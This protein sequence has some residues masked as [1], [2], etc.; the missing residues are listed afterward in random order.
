MNLHK[1]KFQTPDLAYFCMEFG[2]E[3]E[4]PNYAGGLG[5][6]AADILQAL[7]DK[8]INACG[9][10]LMYK[11]GFYA[12]D[13]YYDGDVNFFPRTW[14]RDK[15]LIKQ[16]V[17]T[18]VKIEGREVKI[19]VW[20]Y[21]LETQGK[22]V[23]I[24]LLDTDLS[25][26]DSRDRNITNKLYSGGDYLRLAQEVVLG[27]GGVKVLREMGYEDIDIYHMNEGHAAFLTLQLLKERGFK[28]ERVQENCIFT[29]HTPI[30]AGHDK[31]DYDLAHQVVGD[32]LPWHIQELAGE[33]QLSM[34]ELAFS[35]SRDANAVSRRHK[36]VTQ[37]MFPNK[38]I[39]Y[40]TNG[41][42][43]LRWTSEN[44][45]EVYDEYMPGWRDNP[46]ICEKQAESI[47]DEEFY[48]AHQEDKKE[49]LELVNRKMVNH[50]VGHLD[51]QKVESFY[52]DTETLTISF[53][54]RTVPYKR[55]ELLFRN[56]DRL[57][58]LGEGKLQII[59]AGKAHPGDEFGKQVIK[60]ITKL[61]HELAG[62]INIFYLE[63]YDIETAKLLV[64]GSDVWLN[65]PERPREA[66]GTSGMK[67]A[68]NGMLN[69]SIYDGWWIEG[70]EKCPDSGW[71]I[72]DK[73]LS[74]NPTNDD[75]ADVQSLYNILEKEIIPLY[76]HDRE[77]WLQCSKKAISLMS[78][79]AAKRCIEEYNRKL[80]HL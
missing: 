48:K 12:Q 31:F 78:D 69:F 6:L 51:T 79:F 22:V 43:H 76:Y 73:D 72:G 21:D 44:K 49:L 58:E 54:R 47:P 19:N 10:G 33:N 23:P 16:D 9:V 1:S 46:E 27:I 13:I 66:S 15:Y 4:M 61:S 42:H 36:Q 75:K 60:R 11:E 17:T 62:K 71:V 68:F 30:P 35:L 38:D 20:R 70:Y 8:E 3:S 52:F 29:T 18:T 50:T 14:D 74:D 2:L 63:D 41:A 65:I 28:N 80:W 64:S 53:A 57:L 32:N 25:E 45:A 40:V 56:V 39:E 77:Q 67:A 37:N 7:G 59:F 55:P 26:N 5:I 24:Y 34:T